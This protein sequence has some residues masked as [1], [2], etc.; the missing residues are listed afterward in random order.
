MY[1]NHCDRRYLEDLGIRNLHLSSVEIAGI[2]FTGLEGCVRYKN[3]SSDVLYSQSE[4]CAMVERLPAA[5]VVVSHCPPARIND[6]PG[7]PAHIGI[8]ALRS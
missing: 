4:Y 3:G 5:D 8:T 7:D 1:G 2:T 6:H